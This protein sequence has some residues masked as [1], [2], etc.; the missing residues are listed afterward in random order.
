MVG[1]IVN[2]CLTDDPGLAVDLMVSVKGWCL[3]FAW[4]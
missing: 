4:W 1:K 2:G 3:D